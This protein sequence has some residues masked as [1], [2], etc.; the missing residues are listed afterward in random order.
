MIKAEP[1]KFLLV[2]VL[3]FHHPTQAA[4]YRYSGAN[5]LSLGLTGRCF[6][7]SEEGQCFVG[8]KISFEHVF[9]SKSKTQ[10]PEYKPIEGSIGYLGV[11][12]LEGL[13]ILLLLLPLVMFIVYVVPGIS[14]MIGAVYANYIEAAFY[15]GTLLTSGGKGPIINSVGIKFAS[16]PSQDLD[17]NFYMGAAY[18]FTSF[19]QE[20]SEGGSIQLGLGF[21]PRQQGFMASI[22]FER[23]ILNRK[24]KDIDAQEIIS[25]SRDLG[26]S[27]LV[28][29]WRF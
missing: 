14:W 4:E 20:R 12:G 18:S 16:Y 7:A 19:T 8:R 13:V 11:G 5:S 24:V 10:T 28:L 9:L 26:Q 23:H 22:E 29:G 1:W 17:I 6:S 3:V 2:W 27:S 15:G 25:D 21:V